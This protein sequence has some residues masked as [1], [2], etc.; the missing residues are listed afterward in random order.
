M[1]KKI[2]MSQQTRFI[3]L[4]VISLFLSMSHAYHHHHHHHHRHHHQIRSTTLNVLNKQSMTVPSSSSLYS[5]VSPDQ[6]NKQLVEVK[7]QSRMYKNSW[8]LARNHQKPADDEFKKRSRAMKFWQSIMRRRRRLLVPILIVTSLLLFYHPG[9]AL[10][11]SEAVMTT[12]TT[13]ATGAATTMSQAAGVGGA[14]AVPATTT[15]TAAP[16]IPILSCPVSAATEI[17]LMIRL[18][19][20]A[21]LGSALGMERSFAKHSAGVRTM[22]LVSMGACCFTICSCYGFSNFA[23][24]DVSRMASNVAS[25]VGFVGAGVITTSVHNQDGSNRSNPQNNIVH[26]LTTAAT[27]W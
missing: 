7:V 23:R 16:I 15:T 22:S 11:S 1:R 27:I 18:V 3:R 17:R 2:I 6:S 12:A 10:A 8:L 26:G 5:V 14:A 19:Y 24:V 13:A 25:G 21:L 9:V 20:A 4:I